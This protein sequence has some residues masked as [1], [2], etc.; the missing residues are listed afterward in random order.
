MKKHIFV[1]I[2]PVA[3]LA[4]TQAAAAPQAHDGFQFRGAVG[5]GYLV[6]TFSIPAGLSIA[7]ISL[8]SI[9]YTIHGGAGSLELY[10]GGTPAAGLVL[11]GFFSGVSA[12]APSMTVGGQEFTANDNVRLNFAM[13]GPYVDYYPDPTTGF[14]LLGALGYAQLNLED[15][16]S[17]TK[18]AT[19][20]GLGGGIGYDWWVAD[21]W[22]I[23][24]LGRMSWA[25]MKV[26]EGTT[27]LTHSAVAPT[28]LLSVQYQ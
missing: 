7:G 14:H 9:D 24:V 16:S 19:G 23:G 12:V 26:D 27:T 2:A 1:A 15:G 10:F 4:A 21:E 18:N 6:D 5:G 25:S 13:L 11:G 8:G 20:F 3:F 22:S 17:K 28:L